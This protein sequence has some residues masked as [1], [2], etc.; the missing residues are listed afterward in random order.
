MTDR[1]CASNA[2]PVVIGIAAATGVKL[3]VFG[4]EFSKASEGRTVAN[5]PKFK[6]FH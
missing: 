5:A 2:N 4:S 6:T 3:F 1:T